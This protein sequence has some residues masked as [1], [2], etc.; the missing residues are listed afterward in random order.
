MPPEERE[1]VQANLERWKQM[2][3]EERARVRDNLREF[4]RLSPE[5]RQQ[6]RERF[7]EFRGMSPE[8]K[9]GGAPAHA[10]LPARQPRAA[11]A[12]DGEHAPLAADVPEQR[13]RMRERMRERRRP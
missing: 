1:R 11:R 5:E 10:G 9:A 8:R 6:L 4:Q 12:D 13:E 3:P 7:R 2:P